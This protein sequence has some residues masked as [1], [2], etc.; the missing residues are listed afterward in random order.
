M[1]SQGLPP[2]PPGPPPPGREAHL[3]VELTL[4]FR[5]ASGT[6]V[7]ARA[8]GVFNPSLGDEATEAVLYDPADPTRVV[9]VDGLS[10]A[11]RARTGNWEDVAGLAPRIKIVIVVLVLAFGVSVAMWT[12]WR[13][14]A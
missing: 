10:S 8:I 1:V 14:L 11:A 12:V 3:E 4:E 13:L 6:P 2:V 5:T 9:L 7:Q